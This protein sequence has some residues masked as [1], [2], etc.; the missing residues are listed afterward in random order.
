[1]QC[2]I[3]DLRCKEVID[4]NTG[5]RLG[6][7]I[8]AFI[9]TNTGHLVSIVT[10]GPFRI[11]GMFGRADDVVIPWACI[12]RIGEDIILVDAPDEPRRE[13]KGRRGI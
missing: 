8:D 7:V 2:R 3:A 1:M 5:W 6:Y 4:V 9:D 11:L 13:H 12:K 10:P